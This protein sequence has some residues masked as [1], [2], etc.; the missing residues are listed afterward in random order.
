MARTAIPIQ[1]LSRFAVA[2]FT[3]SETVPGNTVDGMSLVNNGATVLAFRN[4]SGA[5]QTITITIVETV[6]FSPPV[7]VIETI[8][9]GTILGMIGPFPNDIYGNILEF[10]V[11]SASVD[12]AGFSLL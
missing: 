6:D 7:P 11:S 2:D 1:R 3:S 4:T 8:A 12:F 9:T 10:A 5:P